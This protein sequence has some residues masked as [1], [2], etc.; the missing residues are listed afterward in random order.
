MCSHRWGRAT[1]RVLP[2]TSVRQHV[3]RSFGGG[4][5]QHKR[6]QRLG[7]THLRRKLRDRQSEPI[8][9]GQEGVGVVFEARPLSQSLWTV[10]K[11]KAVDGSSMKS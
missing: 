7:G 10:S 1:E 5:T 4:I 8:A 9:F 11:I 6:V 3:G 2:Q